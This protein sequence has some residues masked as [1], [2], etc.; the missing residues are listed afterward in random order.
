MNADIIISRLAAAIE[1]REKMRERWQS[2]RKGIP[3][4]FDPQD[5][6]E[7]LFNSIEEYLFN[8]YT[9]IDNVIKEVESGNLGILGVS[10]LF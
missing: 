8:R 3:V 4:V 1:H 7:E 9:I 5:I 2:W 6:P 10:K